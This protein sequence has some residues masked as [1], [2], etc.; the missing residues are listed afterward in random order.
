MP[1][2]A[3]LALAIIGEVIGTSAMKASDGFTKLA[4]S[5]LTVV[6]YAAAFYFLSQILD[7]IPVG[8]A[9]AVWAGGGI[10]LI[11]LVGWVVFG[12]KPDL[13]GFAGMGRSWRECS[14]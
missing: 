4:P 7:R 11:A 10:V 8:I 14:S 5:V 13:P 9:Y 6:G 1:A 12:Q 3:L 2:Y